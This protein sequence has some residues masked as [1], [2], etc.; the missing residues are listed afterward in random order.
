MTQ[1]AAASTSDFATRRRRSPDSRADFSRASASQRRVALVDQRDFERVAAREFGREA[2][3]GAGHGA[4]GTVDIIRQ[5]D[6]HQVRLPVA[7]Q[8]SIGSQRGPLGPAGTACRG[9]AVRLTVSPQAT[10][11]RRS[12]KSKARTIRFG[13]REDRFRHC[14]R[15][16]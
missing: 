16:D 15:S 14:R 1:A 2:A 4:I 9:E 12:P 11:I 5:A 10:P 7:Q 6:H 8:R 3:R 13:S